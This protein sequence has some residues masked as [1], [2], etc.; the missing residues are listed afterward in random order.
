MSKLT[1]NTKTN[2]H[3]QYSFRSVS[4]IINSIKTSE[5]GGFIVNRPFPTNALLDFDPFLL[6]DEMGP[7]SGN[8][9]KQKEH[10]IIRTDALR[11]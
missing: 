3:Q 1:T 8:Q 2:V 6:L 10:R 5:G 4:R 11:L 7:K 9:E